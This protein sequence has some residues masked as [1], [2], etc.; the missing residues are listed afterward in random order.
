MATNDL[1]AVKAATEALM[2]A[3]DQLDVDRFVSYFHPD[4]DFHNPIGMVL[5]GP[6]EIRDLHEKLYS[7]HPPPGFPSFATSTSTGTIQSARMLC[8]DVALV[9]WTWT[10]QDAAADGTR[11]PDRHGT[12]T[13]VWLRR[14]DDDE[15]GSGWRI[16][17]WR[18]KDFPS[19]FE[20][21]PGYNVPSSTPR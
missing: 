9:D 5:R 20:A 18:D 16:I 6:A 2:A 15:P 10:Q 7:P 11:W 13:L 3:A 12:N 21:P 1:S 17:A 8:P 14:P 19:E 4:A